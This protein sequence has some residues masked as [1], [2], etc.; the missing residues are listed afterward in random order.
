MKKV[1]KAIYAVASITLVA[2][3]IFGSVNISAAE[4]PFLKS[5][6]RIGDATPDTPGETPA[7]T[8]APW[9]PAIP[10]GTPVPETGLPSG[11]GLG[12][13]EV[14]IDKAKTLTVE[15]IQPKAENSI[16][17]TASV[18][19]FRVV[20]TPSDAKLKEQVFITVYLM[21]RKSWSSVKSNAKYSDKYYM[22]GESTNFVYIMHAVEANPYKDGTEDN[23]RFG[24]FMKSAATALQ[25][26][27]LNEIPLNNNILL[28]KDGKWGIMLA[29]NPDK[30]TAFRES[31][32][33]KDTFEESFSY[34]YMGDPV[35]KL[36]TCAVYTAAEWAK[37]DK[38]QSNLPVVVAE[39]NG[40]VVTMSVANTNPYGRSSADFSAF[41]KAKDAVR[42]TYYTFP[43][44][45]VGK[46][47]G[48]TITYSE[49]D[50]GIYVSKAAKKQFVALTGKGDIFIADGKPY[51][52]SAFIR[53]LDGLLK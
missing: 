16:Y 13:G 40:M 38:K 20:Y 35:A 44:I 3:M 53:S 27:R 51:A 43:L 39:E 41:E 34:I 31:K 6:Y 52:T 23:L 15:R 2:V 4:S 32:A 28:A 50:K 22:F 19:V 10:A 25:V 37:I 11:S 42:D 26:F 21:P 14:S 46:D 29:H 48:Y 7:G 45:T 36:A 8:S 49:T 1:V 47:L 5:R 18:D 24:E 9:T 30:A 12:G 33:A 17:A